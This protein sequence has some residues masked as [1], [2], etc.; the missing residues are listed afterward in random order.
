M[1]AFLIATILIITAHGFPTTVTSNCYSRQKQLAYLGGTNPRQAPKLILY[2]TDDENNSQ[3]KNTPE[4]DSRIVSKG[5]NKNNKRTNDDGFKIEDRTLLS[6]DL[7]AILIACELL[8]LI[9]DVIVSGWS[10]FFNP[11]DLDS[12]STLPLL[13][14]RDSMLSIAWIASSVRNHGYEYNSNNGE[15]DGTPTQTIIA[16]FT[17]YT[18]LLILFHFLLPNLFTMTTA[19]TTMTTIGDSNFF[20]QQHGVAMDWLEISRQAILPLAS[21]WTF[22]TFYMGRQ[23]WR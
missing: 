16:S 14:R 23:L 5:Q 20:Q 9:D 10:T 2:M 17:E 1:L 13:V 3:E 18:I 6:I 22:R 7:L 8:G 11:I 19:T 15:N 4:K 21:I 12:F